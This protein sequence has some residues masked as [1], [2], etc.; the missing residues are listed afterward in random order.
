MP[1]ISYEQ[2]KAA[3]A[4]LA[5]SQRELAEAA[6]VA[7]STVADFER[8]LR[9]PMPNNAQA[10]RDALEGK[11]L[12]FMAGGVVA[13]A[14]LPAS[15]PSAR[16]G[17]LLRWVNATDLSVWGE[18]F[19]GKVG[20]PELIRRLI[21]ASVGP[22]A[23]VRFPSDESIQHAGWDGICESASATR[24]IPSG[25][26]GWE[27]GNQRS[28]ISGKANDEFKKRSGKPLG[29]DTRHTT[30][31]FVTSQRFPNRDLW[32]AEKKALGIWRDVKLI[33]GNDLVH[34]LE[35]C[36]GVAQW[37]AVR[38]GRR[39]EGVRNLA[40]FWDEWAQATL[41]PLSPDLVLT[42]RDE[43][44]SAALKW[45][46]SAPQ[47]F[48]IQAEA[49]DE[50]MAFLYA[51][52]SPLPEPYKT[53]YS[54]RCLVVDKAETARELV[55][56]GMTLV[57]AVFEP[58]G[59]L[60]QRLIA[61]GH[62]VFAAYGP[63]ARSVLGVRRLTRPWR[64]D[65]QMALAATGIDEA[66]A[67]RF[68]HA[69]GRSI[70]VLRRIMPAHPG[71]RPKWADQAPPEL[72]AAMLAGAWDEN[73]ARDR[74]II[75]ELA[76]RP[77]EHV[78]AI[79]APLAAELGGPVIR[80]GAAWKVAS[81][82]DLWVQI[83]NQLTPTQLKRFLDAFQS[84]LAVT[85]PRFTRRPKSIYYEEPGEFGEEAS[86]VLRRGLTEAMIA[87][88]VHPDRAALISDPTAQV[89]AAIRKLLHNASPALWWSLSGDF[90]NIAEAAPEEFLNALE[91]GL[92]GN[93][94]SVASLFRS[95]KGVFHPVEYL[96]EL[97]WS[98]E[99][100]A[101][102][103]EYLMRCGLLLARLDE[104]D[105]GGKLLNRPFASLR[106]IFVNW[107]PQTYA[108]LANRLKVIDQILKD[109]SG[110][111]WKLLVALAPRGHY[112]SGYSP[113]P[114]WRDFT[115]LVPEEITYRLQADGYSA[116]GRRLLDLAGDDVVRWV[117]L[118]DLWALFDPDWRASAADKLE[119]VACGIND[120]TRAE[121]LRD[122]LR[123][124]LQ[125]H[126]GFRHSEWAMR[127]DDLEPLDKV[128]A[129]LQPH[130]VVDRVRWLFQPGAARMLLPD[131]H[132]HDQESELQEQ[133]RKAAEDLLSELSPD[134]LFAFSATIHGHRDL[135]AAIAR[136]AVP[137][138]EKLA[139]LKR[140]LTSDDQME[141]EIGI[142]VLLGLAPT[143]ERERERIA[144]LGVLGC[145][146]VQESWGE[147]A[148]LHIVL[149]L[150]LSQATWRYV[151]TRSPS[152][153]KLY[154]ASVPKFLC[155]ESADAAYVVDRLVNV[156]RAC[157]AVHWL[158]L[159]IAQPIAQ[160]I[161]SSIVIKALCAA[162]DSNGAIHVKQRRDPMFSYYVGL[163]LDRL[164]QN[165][166]VSEAELAGLEWSYF[167]ILRYSERPARLLH[168]A[169]ARDPKFFVELIKLL[170]RPAADSGIAEP[171]PEN[172]AQ[173]QSMWKQAFHV[174]RD[175][176][177]IPGADDQRVIDPVA[178]E[179]WVTRARKLLAE[180][181]RG[182]IGDSQIGNIL[183]A[184][185]QLG[186]PPPVP[187]REIIE[188]TRSSALEQGIELGAI[189][190]RGVT[191]RSPHDGGQLERDLAEQYRRN[192]EELRFDWYRTAAILHRLADNYEAQAKLEDVSADQRDWL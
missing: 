2:V 191:V 125:H 103:P 170:F 143:T 183:S 112:T 22:A 77:Y 107:C 9:E 184:S 105:P 23:S 178:L 145:R 43:D 47:I 117:E 124:L 37:L 67:H 61:A 80:S 55:G 24:F 63:G 116:I 4:L 73:S 15:P 18:T 10:I 40:E 120:A 133:Q 49:P 141:K 29:L 95:E 158:G 93:T 57:L 150:P 38:I 175:W 174:L 140:G 111:G 118:L 142:G 139:L 172:L 76:G 131:K 164:E 128:F 68:A 113:K 34:W 100:L 129:L 75:G 179:N 136:T 31:V 65:V 26:S 177:H 180:C 92:D 167:Q 149:N 171:E 98:I 62:H 168:R 32:V 176:S 56:V 102:S 154:W 108:P 1:A 25:I 104:L 66:E 19:D 182:E 74:K 132:W 119:A 187:V 45:L 101:W 161:E 59:G 58:D 148:E 138:E 147:S 7:V 54:S 30:F 188:M 134:Q 135:G 123:H 13:Q 115:P 85:N 127:E 69:S 162:A 96:S 60:A 185:M 163:L 42:G 27:I 39:P 146:A 166:N 16:P 33:D 84:V 53:Y 28:G 130:G 97:L 17:T 155:K 109:Y 181:G 20:M 160:P 89:N 14:M 90:R 186:E 83:G 52:L 50:A 41:K 86:A 151:E 165:P 82:L 12:R 173:A 91:H 87:L 21:F 71:H 70:T 64:F 156:G 3:R 106:Q 110:I 6:R 88:A 94:P 126:R 51:C 8:G 122:G 159:N 121:V 192:A 48:P 99:I 11:G 72:M 79:L 81:L 36:P 46:Y 137:A 114:N 144:Y 157:D 44:Q 78:E 153:S 5:W 35:D 190:R 189:N 152:L 169:L